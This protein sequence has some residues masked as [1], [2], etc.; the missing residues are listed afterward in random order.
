MKI[1]LDDQRNFPTKGDYNCVRTYE[2]CILLLSA[3]KEISFISLDFDLDSKYK[4]YDILVYMHENGIRPKHI[5]IHSD[6][7]YGK[8]Q[9]RCY[10]HKCFH[11]AIVTE[12]KL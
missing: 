11:V 4:G 10:A 12:N 2:A 1:I 7:S 9:M 6:H 5:N 3:F 8:S